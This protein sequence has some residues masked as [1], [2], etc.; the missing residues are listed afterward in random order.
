ME[1]QP[2]AAGDLA[3]GLPSAWR[4]RVGAKGVLRMEWKQDG[5]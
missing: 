2:T 5:C 1:Q 4:G 3:R